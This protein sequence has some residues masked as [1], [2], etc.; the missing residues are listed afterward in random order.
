MTNKKDNLNPNTLNKKHEL[1]TLTRFLG[2]PK[3]IMVFMILTGI[4]FFFLGNFVVNFVGILFTHEKPSTRLFFEFNLKLIKDNSFYKFG[5]IATIILSLVMAIKVRYNFK[6]N[7]TEQNVG[8][9]GDMRW[10][11]QQE[12]KNQ[13]KE[14]PEKNTTF[15]G[16]GGL[17]VA[18]Y[19]DKIYIDDSNTNTIIIGITRSGKGEMFVTPMIDIYSRAE[20]QPSLV[21]TDMKVELFPMSYQML[22]DRGYD[23]YLLDLE[24]PTLG[25]QFNPLELVKQFYLKGDMEAAQLAA[26]SFAYSIYADAASS[27]DAN[28]QFFLDN[29]TAALTGLIVAQ[30]EDADINDKLI[31]CRTKVSFLKAR[32][33][34]EIASA[35]QK[36]K[37]A[38]SCPDIINA[39]NIDSVSL[40]PDRVKFEEIRTEINK[41]TMYS[42]LTTFREL[43]SQIVDKKS[44]ESMLDQYFSLRPPLD[45]ATALFDS[46]KISGEKT[47]ASIYSQFL[48]KLSI[49]QFD[50]IARQTAKSTIDFKELGFGE[51]PIALF[52]GVPFYDRSKDSLVSTLISQIYDVNARTAAGTIER[53][54]KRK[55]VFHLDEIGNFPPIKGLDTMLSIGLGVNLIYN[56]V[57]QSYSQI[58]NKY[59]EAADGI[60]ENCGNT[61]YIQ[62]NSNKTAEDVSK[63][64]GNYTKTNITRSGTMLSQSKSITESYDSKPLMPAENLTKLQPGENIVIRAMKRTDLKGNSVTPYPIFNNIE[65]GTQFKYRYE[66]LKESMP[67]TTIPIK[68]LIGVSNDNEDLEN[69]LLDYDE[70]MRRL[71]FTQLLKNNELPD[72]EQDEYEELISQFIWCLDLKDLDN[73]EL[74]KDILKSNNIKFNDRKETIFG[75]IDKIFDADMDITTKLQIIDL[76]EGSFNYAENNELEDE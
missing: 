14:I 74:I 64:L 56:L 22:K 21:V 59:K 53:K 28:T 35:D 45:R 68:E 39:N 44:G 57:I 32:Y 48:S 71:K 37:Y 13:Y 47:K 5:Y 1:M 75:V 4:I 3:V 25:I 27:T 7:F 38:S 10:T 72:M 54:C 50:D 11:T 61:V 49:Y 41:V 12:I 20:N 46:V 31:N 9:K 65:D 6:V 18:H 24:D 69:Y 70:T 30:L 40:I 66:Y 58:D 60:K 29:A 26:N 2:K 36:V 34:Y 42:V 43:S 76:I 33:Y 19:G 15:K 67:D 73:C 16:F 23:V 8:Q 55:I 52:L 17:P 62:T 51:K 63:L